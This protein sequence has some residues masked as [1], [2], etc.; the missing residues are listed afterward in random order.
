MC[1]VVEGMRRDRLPGL[2]EAAG[3]QGR[4]VAAHVGYVEV[5]KV[6]FVGAVPT[7]A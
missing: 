2:G 7:T 4:P 3:R 1:V 6:Q 5:E